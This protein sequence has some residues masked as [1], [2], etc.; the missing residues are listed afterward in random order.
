LKQKQRP[1]KAGSQKPAFLNKI[2]FHLSIRPTFRF[3]LY[4]L[5]IRMVR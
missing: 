5:L 1:K 4:R 3:S 2:P